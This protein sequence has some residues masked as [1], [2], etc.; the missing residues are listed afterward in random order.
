M[1]ANRAQVQRVHRRLG[2][3]RRKPSSNLE[4]QLL[5]DRLFA[6]I[7]ADCGGVFRRQRHD[8]VMSANGA[9]SI[10]TICRPPCF[11]AKR[12]APDR[13]AGSRQPTSRQWSLDRFGTISSHRSIRASSRTTL[14]A[15]RSSKSGD[16]PPC[17][18]PKITEAPSDEHPSCPMA[19][20]TGNAAPREFPA[21][22]RPA[23]T[24]T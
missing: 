1:W 18:N 2:T 5:R 7:E 23:A 14:S 13:Y 10:G 4:Q 22:L 15:S 6:I 9:S 16:H 8:C 12:N 3:L 24:S 19:L 11:G 20:N 17:A 21:Y